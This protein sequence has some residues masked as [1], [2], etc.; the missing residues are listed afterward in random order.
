METPP[1][2]GRFPPI[3]P[4][5]SLLV[6]TTAMLPGTMRG[7]SISPPGGGTGYSKT[8]AVPLPS[9]R[10]CPVAPF[11]GTPERGTGR[12]IALPFYDAG[13]TTPAF[14]VPY[15]GDLGTYVLGF[16]RDDSR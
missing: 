6:S 12:F 13:L 5:R 15:E 3:D 2:E 7:Q 10:L 16:E 8:G 9:V 4:T 11:I 1:G 14:D